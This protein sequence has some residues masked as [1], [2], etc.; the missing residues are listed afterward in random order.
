MANNETTTK[1]KVDISELKKSMQE[2]RKQVAYANSEFKAVSSSM[3]DW[4]KSSDGLNAK[5][6]QLKSNL[7]SQETVLKEYENILEEVKKEYGENSKEAVEYATKLNNQQAVVNKIKKEMAG[8]E[9]AL[10]E[11]SNAEKIASKTGKEVAEVLDEMANNSEN[12]GDGFTV[13]KGAIA[14]FVGNGL[15][16]LV[17]GL[18][19]AATS[20]LGL[21]ESTREYRNQMAK[22]ESASSEA[23]YSTTYTANKYKELYGVLADETAVTTTISNFMALETSGKTLDSLLNSSIGIWAK[24]GDSIALDGLAEAVNH[25]SQLGSVQGNLADA[26]E[27][28]G[29]TVDEFNAQLEKCNTEQER[30]QLIATTLDGLYGELANTYKENN[31][32]VIASNQA[33]AEYTKTL[34]DMGA[35]IEPVTTTLKTGFT[36]LLN[37]ALALFGGEVNIENFTTKLEE[38]FGV[39]TETVLPAVK[40]GLGWIKDNKDI[41]IAGLSGVSAGLLLMA[42][43][44][45]ALKIAGV[46][47]G[48]IDTFRKNTEKMTVAQALFNTVLGANPMVKLVAII[49]AVVTAIVTF[50][51]TNDEARAKFLEIWGMI[52]EGVRNAINSIGKFFTETFPAF[53]NKAIDFLKQLPVKFALWLLAVIVKVTEWRNQMITKAQETALA[54]V[55]KIIEFVSQLGTQVWTWLVHV[56]TLV[57]EWGINLANK[58]REAAQ[59][60]VS[61]VVEK[62]QE[63]TAKIKSIGSDIVTGL[64]NGINDKVQWLKD[65]IKGFVGNVTSWLKQ[66]FEIGSP[67]KLMAREIGRW[68]PEGIA[69]GVS[70]NAKSVLGAM[71]DLTVDT[72]GSVRAGLS[73]ATTSGGAGTVGGGVVNNF[74]QVINSPKQLSRLDIYRQSKNLLGFA[75]GGI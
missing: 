4:N 21:A 40:D 35:R 73:T 66:F 55:N 13:F 58:G 71:K 32:S 11:V 69:V 28:G 10:V 39:L 19:D 1:F 38:G 51:A 44:F 24:Y 64:W 57:A 52:V 43:H 16:S 37:T 60:L 7:D 72:V 17:G 67:S 34:A 63:I 50:I 61:A 46:V 49:L 30:Q 9:D 45:T 53:L 6:K 42:T 12:A 33:Q 75:G 14:T 41:I 48:L 65:K 59:K 47:S 20:I 25:T 8:Y 2:A 31:A 18:R 56:L 62:V 3:D 29:I 74:T 54:F 68:L 36:D 70:D 27:W 22:L 15:T 23:G 26:L 5:L